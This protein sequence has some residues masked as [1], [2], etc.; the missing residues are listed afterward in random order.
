M[1]AHLKPH[2]LV[3]IAAILLLAISY[4]N[5]AEVGRDFTA[6]PSSSPVWFP[7]SLA[8]AAVL[9]LGYWVLPG[10]FIGSFLTSGWVYMNSG[11]PVSTLLLLLEALTISFGSVLGTFLG[12]YLLCQVAG[13]RSPFDRPRDAFRFLL[14]CGLFGPAVSITIG[15][16][17][18]AVAGNIAWA[19]YGIVWFN[20]WISSA[21]GILTV[22]PALLLW[23]PWLWEN[24]FSAFVWVWRKFTHRR[25]RSTVAKPFALQTH[26]ARLKTVWRSLETFCMV[27]LVLLLSY[28]AFGR[29]Y[30]VEYMLMPFLVWA[31]FRFGA[32]GA[33]LMLVMVSTI[34]TIGTMRGSGSFN[35]QDTFPDSLLLQSFIGVVVLTTLLLTAAIAE[36]QQITATLRQ[37]DAQLRSQAFQ[38]EQA[39]LNLRR[40]QAQL[41]QTEKIS[42]L[43]QLVA[44]V[45]HEVSNPVSFIAGNLDHVQTYVRDLFSVL[46]LYQHHVSQTPIEI[47]EKAKEVDLDYLLEDLP[48]ALYSMQIGAE[49]IREIMSSLRTFS[50][51]DSHQEQASDIHEGL[52]ST[53]LILQHRLKAKPDRPEIRLIRK[54]GNL[55]S[56]ECFAG[57]LNQ[58]FMNLIANAIDA[59]DEYSSQRSYSDIERD[60]NVIEI[61]TEVAPDN[62]VA[63]AIYNNGPSIPDD[64]QQRLFDAFYTTKPAG[65]GTGL[66][67]SI[68]H[69]IVVEQ[70]KGQL[71]CFSVAGWGTEFLIKIPIRKSLSL[72]PQ[73]A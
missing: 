34:A 22:T 54:Y 14:Y 9:L 1:K 15:V 48:K 49:R 3:Q 68:S 38:L 44:G 66:G 25:V 13:Y 11:D 27:G 5:A 46:E 37:S 59:L 7:D 19:E 71:Q 20:G 64:V 17:T 8:V 47:K 57:Q 6:Y 61:R 67:L 62:C 12:A 31:A 70:H 65:K 21:S 39:L 10:V 28:L 23:A 45:A 30:P 58:V 33:T 53:L 40:T 24:R 55:P 18:L 56:V 42:S 36:R 72:T 52:D 35:M 29:G 32:G 60:P 2:W 41:V 69:Q 63:I 26:K 43:G 50:R 16:T 51:V 73:I 4:Y